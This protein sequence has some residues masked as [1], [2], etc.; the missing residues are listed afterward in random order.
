MSERQGK[1]Q[2]D[3]SK[4]Q[5][6]P[7]WFTHRCWT[8]THS[9]TNWHIFR[10]T[11]PMPSGPSLAYYYV[12]ISFFCWLFVVFLYSMFVFIE[13]RP[14]GLSSYKIRNYQGVNCFISQS[15]VRLAT[16]KL[17]KISG[18]EFPE[19]FYHSF[20]ACSWRHDIAPSRL[21]FDNTLN[22]THLRR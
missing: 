5:S 9:D 7:C 16:Y 14:P 22:L 6:C 12:S 2:I 20:W 3:E 11:L 18:W 13:L 17:F 19:L 4:R 1:D 8:T 15:L 21:Y 10:E